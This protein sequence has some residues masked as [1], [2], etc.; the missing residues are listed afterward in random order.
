MSLPIA[1]DEL[2]QYLANNKNAYLS[3]QNQQDQALFNGIISMVT[4]ATT[5]TISNVNSINNAKPQDKASAVNSAEIG[6]TN[7]L[8]GAI[9]QGVSLGLNQYY[10][11]AQFDLNIDNMKNAP[12]SVSNANGSAIFAN[13][14]EQYGVYVEIYEGINAE[15]EIANDI[16]YRDGFTYNRFGNIKD[17]DNIR[18]YFN[19]IKAVIGNIGGIAIS[20]N[21]RNDLRQRFLNG[22]RFW[23]T[24]TIDYSKENI[25]KSIEIVF[26]MDY[27]N[28]YELAI[29]KLINTPA[30]IKYGDELKT[31]VILNDGYNY[32]DLEVNIFAVIGTTTTQLSGTFLD[33]STGIITLDTT[34]YSTILKDNGTIRIS[35][36]QSN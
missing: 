20:N 7:G 10:A 22:V 17:F 1:N 34:S 21:A 23:N 8:I 11:Q 13:T 18:K 28:R 24:D 14:F 27:D 36:I 6:A 32:T 31:K 35:I 3:F 26:E 12:T 19:Y 15:L 30:T 2:S 29:N 16:M 25:E 33:T 9:G 5:N 4:G